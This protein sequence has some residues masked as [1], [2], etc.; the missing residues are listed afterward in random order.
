MFGNT[1]S[2]FK[3]LIFVTLCMFSLLVAAQVVEPAS[4]FASAAGLPAYACAP[5]SIAGVNVCFPGTEMSPFQVAATATGA[6]GPVVQMQLWADG[7]K[8]S[9][10]SGNI[11][12]QPVQLSPGNHVLTVVELESTGNFIKSNPFSID[13]FGSTEGEQCA[14]PTAPG[15]HICSPDFGSSCDVQGWVTVIAAGT[16]AA[17]AVKRME[18]WAGN[19]KIANFPGNTINTSLPLPELTPITII[20][21]DSKGGFIKAHFSFQIC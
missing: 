8:I 20:E 1:R 3:V 13:V 2:I 21:I 19:Q 4:S 17:G 5:P 16:G 7:K 18:L 15:V 12:D 9:Q 14:P 11:F 10:V 6:D